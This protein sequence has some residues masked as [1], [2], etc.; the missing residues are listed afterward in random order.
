MYAIR[1]RLP[2]LSA[3]LVVS[4]LLLPGAPVAA[5]DGSAPGRPTGLTAMGFHGGIALVQDTVSPYVMLSWDDPGD[6]G[7][8]H[9]LVLRQDVGT[10]LRGQFIV[11]DRDTGSSQT[12]YLDRSVE[13]NRHYV[14]RVA[15]V[16][17]HGE[18]VRSS[19][20]EAD[21]YLVAIV[22]FPGPADTPPED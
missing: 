9:Y 1:R 22:P 13:T 18:S 11:I 7:I 5:H 4:F 6:T 14:Y 20:A 15:A 2:I 12:Q 10:H 21:T 16:N 17:E 8:T 19:S 3:A